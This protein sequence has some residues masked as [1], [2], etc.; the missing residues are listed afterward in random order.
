MLQQETDKP[1]SW[2]ILHSPDKTEHNA[3][4]AGWS[5]PGTCARHQRHFLAWY[6]LSQ[7]FSSFEMKANRKS[8]PCVTWRRLS[9]MV[10]RTRSWEKLVGN[11]QGRATLSLCPA[12]T[13]LHWGSPWA[14]WMDALRDLYSGEKPAERWASHTRSHRKLKVVFFNNWLWEISSKQYYKRLP[15]RRVKKAGWLYR[16]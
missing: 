12:V 16:K 13:A 3:S 1:G 11:A 14:G 5:P 9:V 6:H 15:E 2:N 10:T 7:C 8:C 4:K